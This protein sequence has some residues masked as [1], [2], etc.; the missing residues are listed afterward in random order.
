MSKPVNIPDSFIHIGPKVRCTSI[1]QP[2]TLPVK[3]SRSVILSLGPLCALCVLCGDHNPNVK[4]L[5]VV[6]IQIGGLVE[7]EGHRHGDI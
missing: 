1:A 3:T 5:D 6:G 2:I 7:W 4:A